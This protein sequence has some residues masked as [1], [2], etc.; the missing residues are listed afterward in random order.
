MP[1]DSL[2][3]RAL[4]RITTVTRAEVGAPAQALCLTNDVSMTDVSIIDSIGGCA[5]AK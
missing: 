3:R 4:V 5:G 1:P 2:N